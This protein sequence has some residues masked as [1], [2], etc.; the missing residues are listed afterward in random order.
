MPMRTVR[1]SGHKKE[2]AE[3]NDVFLSASPHAYFEGV[4]FTAGCTSE[5]AVTSEVTSF[6]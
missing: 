4:S 3:K 6:F 2:K 1:G 5:V